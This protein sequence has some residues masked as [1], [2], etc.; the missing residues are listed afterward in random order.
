MADAA[1]DA[2]AQTYERERRF[3][4]TVGDLREE[5]TTRRAGMELSRP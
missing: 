4:E 1:G 5:I 3:H 2:R